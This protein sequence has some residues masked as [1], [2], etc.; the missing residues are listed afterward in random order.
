[1]LFLTSSITDPHQDNSEHGLKIPFWVF[2]PKALASVSFWIV[3]IE[4]L[5]ASVPLLYILFQSQIVSLKGCT[6]EFGLWKTAS[7]SH[8]YNAPGGLF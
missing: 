5:S 8:T 6:S 1:M 7:E 2:N 4:A 3:L